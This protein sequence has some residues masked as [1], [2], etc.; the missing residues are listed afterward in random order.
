MN[1]DDPKLT[2]YSVRQ[3]HLSTIHAWLKKDHVKKFFYGKG[4]ENTLKDLS[5]FVD[6]SSMKE[7]SF[8]DHWIAYIEDQPL[9]YLM[10]S[11]ISGPFDPNDDYD[12]WYDKE[13]PTITLDLLIGEEK[14]LGLGLAKKM[15]K[16]FLIDKF[17]DMSRV[18]I[19]PGATNTKAIHV[20]ESVGFKKMEQFLPSYNPNSSLDD[21]VRYK[22]KFN[23][24]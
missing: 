7:N 1:K 10:T 9:G 2:F 15:I 6:K 4:L 16:E 17:S 21:D 18:L 24:N 23:L 8:F 13:K 3:K 12:K 20:Y 22:K 11:S 5:L 14:Y 19:D